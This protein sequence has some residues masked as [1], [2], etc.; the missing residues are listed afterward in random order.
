MR[1]G[2][3][4]RKVYIQTLSVLLPLF[5]QEAFNLIVYEPL[6]FPHHMVLL[7]FNYDNISVFVLHSPFM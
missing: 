2:E 6:S 3:G 4:Y 7:T 1:R 5:Y